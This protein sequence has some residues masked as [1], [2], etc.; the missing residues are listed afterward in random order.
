[1]ALAFKWTEDGVMV[2]IHPKHADTQFC[3]GVTYLLE[4]VHERNMAAHRG[5]MAGVNE[6]WKN[7]PEDIAARFPSA[8]A[9]R[10]FAL[11]RT[12]FCHYTERVLDT[13]KDAVVAASIIAALDEFAIV[14][15]T[16]NVVRSWRPKS[17]SVNAMNKEE[18]RASAKAVEDFLAGMIGVPPETVA[19]EAGRSPA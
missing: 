13:H 16:K 9:L 4:P 15:V 5:Y 10:K 12:G 3:V 18:F 1:M 19:R 2:P 8:E 7:L 11:C 14:E 6:V 17:Q